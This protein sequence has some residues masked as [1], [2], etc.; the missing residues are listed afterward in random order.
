MSSN[1][2]ETVTPY[3]DGDRTKKDQVAEM[4]DNIAGNY[5]FLN[6]FL[7]MGIDIRWRKKAIRELKKDQPKTLLDIATGTGDFALEAMSLNPDKI[8]GLDISA[9]MLEVGREKIKKKNLSDKITMQ[10][11]DSENLPFETN[12][13]DAITVAFGVRNFE[14]P[15]VGLTEMYRVLKPG[16]KVA[17]IEFSKPRKFPIKQLYFFYFLKV[18]PLIGRIVSKDHRAYSYLPESVRAFPD[19]E[20]FLQILRGIGYT[21]LKSIPLTFGIA[22]LYIGKKE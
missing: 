16:G 18:L 21:E 19:G 9:G 17:I 10:L 20:D 22:S 15:K 7:S 2:P 3:Q 13:F 1:T 14:R 8:T 11:G 12:T 5:D 6:H 4:F